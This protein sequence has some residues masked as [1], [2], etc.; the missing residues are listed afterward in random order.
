MSEELDELIALSD[1]ILVMYEGRIVGAMDAADA[2][3]GPIGLLM[4][5]GTPGNL[6][7][8]PAAIGPAG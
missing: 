2:D 1:R 8:E 5:G 6:A 3:I 7:P 4:T